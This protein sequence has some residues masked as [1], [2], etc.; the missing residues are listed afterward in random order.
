MRPALCWFPE[1]GGGSGGGF[2]SRLT[3]RLPT[4]RPEDVGKFEN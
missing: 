1:G 2:S 3:F 4:P